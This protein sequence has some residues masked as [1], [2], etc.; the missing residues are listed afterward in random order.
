ML[1]SEKRAD[2]HETADSFV[3]KR[4][5]LRF[6]QLNEFLKTHCFHIIFG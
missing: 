6:E 2:R 3:A 1:P 5:A 4:M